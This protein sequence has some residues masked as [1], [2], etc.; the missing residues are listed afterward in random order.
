MKLIFEDK[1]KR[2]IRNQEEINFSSFSSF[3]LIVITARARSE[4]QISKTATDDEELTVK[5]DGKAFPKL[6]SKEALLDSPAAFNGGQL[7][8]LAKTVYFLTFLQGREHTI[9]LET[10]PPHNTAANASEKRRKEWTES[11]GAAQGVLTETLTDPTSGATNFHSFTDL[12]DF[13]SWATK[14]NYKLTIGGIH[15]YELEK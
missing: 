9:T 14:E 6:G 13:P 8:N 12:A 11:Y 7:H 10:D 4:K 2:I 1:K 15:F 3:H 5:I